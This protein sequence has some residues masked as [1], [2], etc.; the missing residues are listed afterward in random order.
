MA[1]QHARQLQLSPTSKTR[2]ITL[3]DD[4]FAHSNNETKFI[5]SIDKFVHAYADYLF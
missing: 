2:N 4:L 3:L 5:Q 1:T